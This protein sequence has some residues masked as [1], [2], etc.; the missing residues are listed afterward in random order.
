MLAG[1]ALLIV[2][3]FVLARQFVTGRYVVML[4]LL[5]LI[6]TALVLRSLAETAARERRQGAFYLALGL[7][8]ALLAVDGLVSFGTRKDYRHQGIAWMRANL[9]AHARVFSNDRILAWYSGGRF[10]W[11]E[12]MD[13][14][15]LIGARR[16][17]VA[18]VA[19]WILQRDA[20]NRTLDAPLAAYA[21]QLVPLARFDSGRDDRIEVYRVAPGAAP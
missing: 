1:T 9:P 5:A 15:E 17:P 11:D 10:E 7:A 4:C 19:Y 8:I 3:T 16:A 18:G 13:A 21:P 12:V 20:R 2:V 14:E 6:P